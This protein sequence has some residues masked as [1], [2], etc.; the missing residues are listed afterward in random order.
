MKKLKKP[1]SLKEIVRRVIK[2]EQTQNSL[3]INVGGIRYKVSQNGQVQR[4]GSESMDYGTDYKLIGATSDY[5]RGNR[6]FVK[7]DVELT[8]Q[9]IFNNPDSVV[10]KYPLTL[11]QGQI[12][13]RLGDSSNG[14]KESNYRVL[15]V[16]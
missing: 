10:G 1:E 6:R 12:G 16:K 2:E 9:D 15:W 5:G 4:L 3:T 14:N 8:L 7:S 13:M 11:F